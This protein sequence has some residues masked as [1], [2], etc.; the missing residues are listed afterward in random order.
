MFNDPNS[1]SGLMSPYAYMIA[2]V[3]VAARADAHTKKRASEDAEPAKPTRLNNQPVPTRVR[4]ISWRRFVLSVCRSAA[5]VVAALLSLG[6]AAA[7]PQTEEFKVRM[8]CPADAYVLA[9]HL[10]GLS[11]VEAVKAVRREQRIVVTYDSAHLS[12]EQ[13]RTELEGIGFEE[14]KTLLFGRAPRSASVAANN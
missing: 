14:P 10:N 11:G 9:L 1:P 5:A 13:I 8:V 2:G 7:D 12:G 6:V 3:D 4:P